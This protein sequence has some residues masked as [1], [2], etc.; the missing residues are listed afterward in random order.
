ML[1]LHS[2]VTFNL[3]QPASMDCRHTKK[4]MLNYIRM[5]SALEANLFLH[6]Q[7]DLL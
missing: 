2:Q 5:Q 7:P 3:S 4:K 6:N 1:P